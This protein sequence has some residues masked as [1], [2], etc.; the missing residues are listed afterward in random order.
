MAEFGWA[1]LSGAVTGGG[2]SGSIQYVPTA[3]NGVLTGS[4]Q[5]T[6]NDT[7]KTLFLSGTVIVSGTLQANTFDVIHTNRIEIEQ[8]GPSSFG[9]DADDLH[10]FSGSVRISGS[11]NMSYKQITT[12]GTYTIQPHT[13]I[14]GI[15]GSG[16]KSI[17]LPGATGVGAGR[18]VT[19]KDE[20]SSYTRSKATNTHIAVTA[21]G[22]N[23]IEHQTTFDIEGDSVSLSLY[24]DGASK[25][26]IY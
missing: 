19:I 17:N 2:P 8:Y 18:I 13:M 6:W 21:S 14:L 4:Q 12:Q 11:M 3:P 26:F 5:F 7:S 20:Y 1:F 9:D 24:S 22:G 16:Y 10:Q 25:W 15:S 23:K